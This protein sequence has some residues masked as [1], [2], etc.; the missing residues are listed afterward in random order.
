MGFKR[1]GYFYNSQRFFFIRKEFESSQIVIAN[2]APSYEEIHNKKE[3]R[4]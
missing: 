2:R 3:N 4:P 1:A